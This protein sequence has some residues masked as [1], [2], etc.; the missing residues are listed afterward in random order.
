MNQQRQTEYQLAQATAE[1]LAGEHGITILPTATGLVLT[2]GG[3]A[4]L[5]ASIRLDEGWLGVWVKASAYIYRRC[6]LGLRPD[7]GYERVL[8]DAVAIYREASS[9]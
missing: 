4:P 8:D 1:R 5:F 2:R 6:V 3:A 9:E 7:A